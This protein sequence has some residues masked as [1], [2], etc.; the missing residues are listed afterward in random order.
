[1]HDDHRLEQ[2]YN[3]GAGRCRNGAARSKG[4]I[5]GRDQKKLHAVCR[6][7]FSHYGT[8]VAH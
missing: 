4:R 2:C 1:M 3:V 7:C 6:A 5:G 8:R